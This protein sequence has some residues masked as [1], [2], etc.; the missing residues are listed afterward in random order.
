MSLVFYSEPIVLNWK[1]ACVTAGFDADEC[2]RVSICQP[3]NVG[4]S[5]LVLN[6]SLS[7]SCL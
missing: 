4:N 6:D 1:P 7:A 5:I 3:T 2:Y